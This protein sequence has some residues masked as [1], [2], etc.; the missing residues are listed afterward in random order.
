[1][2]KG[3]L[4]SAGGSVIINTEVSQSHIKT[5]LGRNLWTDPCSP[6]KVISYINTTIKYTYIH[7]CI[8]NINKIN[9]TITCIYMTKSQ[10]TTYLSIPISIIGV[11]LFFNYWQAF[12]F[13]VEYRKFTENLGKNCSSTY[14]QYLLKFIAYLTNRNF[15]DIE[16]CLEM[17]YEMKKN[18]VAYGLIWENRWIVFFVDM[19]LM[20]VNWKFKLILPHFTPEKGKYTQTNQKDMFCFK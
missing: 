20:E 7:T 16:L 18:G 1:M 11:L 14:Q 13:R 9:T 5:G 12:A 8:L 17:S 4:D 3:T 19:R 10:K 2:I 15:L 6:Q